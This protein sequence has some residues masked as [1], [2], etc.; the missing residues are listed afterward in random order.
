MDWID[1]SEQEHVAVSCACGN[2]PSAPIK[3]GEY[4]D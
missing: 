2:E 1:V 4:L 3:R